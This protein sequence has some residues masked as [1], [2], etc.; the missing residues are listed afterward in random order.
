[1]TV[2]IRDVRSDDLDAALA[3]NEAVVPHVNSVSLDKMAWFGD[4]ADYFR[5]AESH[6]IIAGMLV[7]FRPGSSY[8]SRFYHWFCDNFEDFAYIDRVAV[9]AHARRSGVARQLY[10]DFEKHF[11][12]VVPALA[13]EVNVLPPNAASMSFHTS[14]GFEQI[15]HAV[16]EP[17]VREVARLLKGI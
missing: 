2:T 5:V 3:L 11:E 14:M 16:I 17:G 15:E 10:I 8:E 6:G 13:C 1:M 4:F 12:H 9:A 7:G